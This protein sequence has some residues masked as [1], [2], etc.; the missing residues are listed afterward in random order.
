LKADM[1]AFQAACDAK[2]DSFRQELQSQLQNLIVDHDGT[3]KS[4]R[5][6][7]KFQVETRRDL[8]ALTTAFEKQVRRDD[9]GASRADRAVAKFELMI[10]N[11][12][13]KVQQNAEQIKAAKTSSHTLQTLV[14]QLHKSHTILEHQHRDSVSKNEGLLDRIDNLQNKVNNVAE[15]LGDE[16]DDM[17]DLG[18]G[19][20]SA[21]NVTA[22]TAG[23]PSVQIVTQERSV[24]PGKKD[25]WGTVSRLQDQLANNTSGIQNLDQLI[26]VHSD[27]LSSADARAAGLETSLAS[28]KETT[29][30]LNDSTVKRIGS[31]ETMFNHNEQA[32]RQHRD[33]L[34]QDLSSF[35][36]ETN[37]RLDA[38][39]MELD[40]AKAN[41]TK[42]AREVDAAGNRIRTLQGEFKTTNEDITK[43][44]QA[45]EVS[46]Q[47][48]QGLQKGFKQTRKQQKEDKALARESTMLPSLKAAGSSGGYDSPRPS[49]RGNRNKERT[50]PLTLEDGSKPDSQVGAT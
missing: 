27:Q 24:P 18:G 39:D 1:A 37:S 35:K 30:R 36:Q 46:Q 31:V 26:Q 29:H 6:A 41:I 25:I 33:R 50:A 19:T 11:T 20:H 34:T 44:R 16:D 45:L 4:L 13:M 43:L 9:G 8:L 5:A 38:H 28:V 14:E 49:S 15:A 40:G 2:C 22:D 12:D 21:P 42:N 48:W 10:K 7:E 32:N 47:Y 3:V 23:G 17:P